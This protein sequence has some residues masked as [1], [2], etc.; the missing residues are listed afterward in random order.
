MDNSNS[1]ILTTIPQLDLAPMEGVTTLPT[2][3]WFWLTS[4]PTAMT[5]P[6]LRVTST[7]PHQQIPPS[8]APELEL[9]SYV[10]YDLTPQLMASDA[11]H[12]IN[13]TKFFDLKGYA[14]E[15]NSGCPSPTCVG[16]G[17]GSSLLQDKKHFH[18]F[19]SRIQKHL[20]AEKFAVKMRTG[21]AD[22]HEFGELLS[23]IKTIP[24]K[25]LTIHGRTRVDRYTGVA[26]W[27]LI[28]KAA[29]DLPIPVIASGDINGVTTFKDRLTTAPHI[30]RV[31]VGRGLLRNPW[32]F[33]EIRTQNPVTLPC[34][35]LNLALRS[36]AMLQEIHYR[37]ISTQIHTHAH[38][39]L[40][41]QLAQEGFLDVT[42]F[43]WNAKLL[44]LQSKLDHQTF[45]E[46][47]FSSITLGRLKMVWN[48]LRSS[49]PEEFSTPTI[50]RTKTV[51]GF[52][53]GIN[54][55]VSHETVT[56]T[57]NPQWD[58]LYSGT[59]KPTAH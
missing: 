44:H 10:P 34:H 53:A 52:F 23:I 59:R 57:H 35:E 21:Y 31:I 32:L 48:Y 50:L 6:F 51:Q 38:D 14:L 28:E 5:T 15:L 2:R 49:L 16:K 17:A 9:D 26:D 41:S 12:F 22:K 30:S 20:G 46:I 36:Y 25:R 55:I 40:L 1:T 19:L 39:L 45:D 3:F 29:S 42:N 54:Q 24:M 58:W 8:F 43:D 4:E 18:D 13:A 56:L 37:D 27:Q 7:F 47:S 11:E 33:H